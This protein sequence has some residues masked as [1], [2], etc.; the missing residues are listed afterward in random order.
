MVESAIKVDF[1]SA[2]KALDAMAEAAKKH[3]PRSMAVAAGKVF[4]DEAAAR[5]PQGPTSNLREAIYLAFSDSRSVPVDGLV[6]YS[7][8]WNKIK[9]PHGH[10]IEFG[11]WQ[12]HATYIGSDGQWYSDRRRPLANPKWIPA[13]PFL[14]PAYDSMVQIA[15]Q[16]AVKRGRE[17]MAEILADPTSLE[18]D[19]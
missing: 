10:L 8:T 13:H 6:V 4:R 17:R 12:T 11:H 16:A 15:M 9:A 1:E 5:A 19:E 3:L 2:F 14:R 18:Q 7:V